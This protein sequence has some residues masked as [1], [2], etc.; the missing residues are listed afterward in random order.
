LTSDIFLATVGKMGATHDSERVERAE[1]V[2]IV[3]RRARFDATEEQ[4]MRVADAWRAWAGQLESLRAR[5]D[6]AEETTGG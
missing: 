4:V 6:V 5:L 2:R 1:E 3:L